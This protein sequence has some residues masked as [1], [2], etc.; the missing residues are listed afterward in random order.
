MSTKPKLLDCPLC[1][2]KNVQVLIHGQY[3]S[4]TD[5]M[6]NRCGC[7]AP[8]ELWNKRLPATQDIVD[9]VAAVAEKAK[10]GAWSKGEHRLAVEILAII[11]PS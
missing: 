6:C 4:E 3:D 11:K 1:H 7:R 9:Q 5:G 10:R 8:L 2:S